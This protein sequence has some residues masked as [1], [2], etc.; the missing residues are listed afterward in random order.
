[1][2]HFN[3]GR[4]RPDNVIRNHKHGYAVRGKSHPVY[5]VWHSM[6]ARCRSKQSPDYE[7]YLLRGI[8]VCK[9]WDKFLNFF[10]DMADT[11][12]PGLT[13]ERVKNDKGYN[14]KNCRWASW[15]AQSRNRRNVELISYGG[16][17]LTKREW[18]TELGGNDDLIYVRLGRGWS[19]KRAVSTPAGRLGS[20]G[21]HTIP[22]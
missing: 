22:R 8:K 13:I 11:Y 16:K 21:T 15:L 12:L 18:G 10:A 4:K 7:N 9:R 19:V 1:M 20:N 2:K 5:K 6:R 3:C 14:K 17:T